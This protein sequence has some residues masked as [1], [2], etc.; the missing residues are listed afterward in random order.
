MPSTATAAPRCRTSPPTGLSTSRCRRTGASCASGTSRRPWG[1]AG[2][3]ATSAPSTARSSTST[4]PSPSDF[5]TRADAFMSD[6]DTGLR[7]G[8]VVMQG[9]GGSLYF[10]KDRDVVEGSERLR[11]EIRDRVTGALL[12]SRYLQRNVDYVVRYAEGQV[13][14]DQPLSLGGRRRVARGRGPHQHPG[15]EPRVPGRRLQLPGEPGLQPPRRRRLRPREL[16]APGDG[17]GRRPGPGQ[18]RAA[19]IPTAWWG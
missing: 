3:S 14:L 6:G 15:R 19:P 11:V 5:R 17:G 8:H 12:S 9:T 18:R 4:R 13:I 2:S 10:L 16:E 1:P 7:Y